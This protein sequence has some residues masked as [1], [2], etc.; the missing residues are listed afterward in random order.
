MS[1]VQIEEMA[2]DLCLIDR[3]KHLPQEECNNTT[4]AHCEAEALYNAGYRKQE[5]IS[6]EDR[7]PERNGRYFTHCCVDGQS[8]VCVL[9]YN[10]YNGFDEDTVTHWM[11]LPQPPRMKGG[12]E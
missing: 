10:K 4:C 9:Y 5:W 2:F 11:P 8:L 12:A 1:K 3:C 7:L 6:V